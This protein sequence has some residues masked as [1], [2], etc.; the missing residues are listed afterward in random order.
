MDGPRIDDRG[1]MDDS[2]MDDL[3]R[4]D[5]RRIVDRGR[6]D[7]QRMDDLGRMDDRR[8][9]YCARVDDRGSA[10]RRDERDR[11]PSSGWRDRVLFCLLLKSPLGNTIKVCIVG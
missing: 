3:G 9:D 2:R 5:D 1:K 4:M 10:W 8:M 6:M 7:N 11:P